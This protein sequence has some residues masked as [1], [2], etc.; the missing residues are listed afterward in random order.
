MK[1]GS[2]NQPT[3]TPRA[4]TSTASALPAS[5]PEGWTNT[6]L[7]PQLQLT[8]WLRARSKH[9]MKH[10]VALPD[11]LLP[12][13]HN[14]Q[15]SDLQCS[16]YE[17]TH[18]LFPSLS[19]RPYAHTNGG[20]T[21]VGDVLQGSPAIPA[22]SWWQL[23]CSNTSIWS[24][25]WPAAPQGHR[26]VRDRH[27]RTQT[28]CVDSLLVAVTVRTHCGTEIQMGTCMLGGTGETVQ[29][30][31]IKNC[32]DGARCSKISNPFNEA[33][34]KTIPLKSFRPWQQLT[35]DPSSLV[36]FYLLSL[37]INTTTD[38]ANYFPA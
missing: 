36:L 10:R 20:D 30:P 23:S 24:T 17:R 28:H 4:G 9:D 26:D 37:E 16:S 34:S 7:T 33:F 13:H 38:S 19:P 5:A 35:E 3:A 18:R 25:H 11:L 27:P 15:M 32:C 29:E 2:T 14:S 8:W 6:I 21:T 12:L 31:A 1:T 22:T